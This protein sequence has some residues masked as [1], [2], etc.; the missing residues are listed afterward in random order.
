MSSSKANLIRKISYWAGA[1]FLIASLI[2]GITIGLAIF[3]NP[4]PFRLSP[5]DISWAWFYGLAILGIGATFRIWRGRLLLVVSLL[6]LMALIFV[7]ALK[8][9]LSTAMAVLAWWL[10]V[11]AGIGHWILIRF[12]LHSDLSFL[13]LICFGIGLGF[14]VFMLLGLIL[15]IAGLYYP[16]AAY[17]ILLALTVALVPYFRKNFLPAVQPGI[18]QVQVSWREGDLRL[19]A[20]GASLLLVLILG[21]Y[22]W[23]FAPPVRFDTLTYQ[24]AAPEIYIRHHSMVKI[25]E[26]MN[27]MLVHYA[28]MLYTYGML[29][30]GERLPGMVH[31]VFGLLATGLTYTLGK[32]LGNSY[33]GLIAALAFLSTPL[34]SVEIG[35]AYIDFITCFYAFAAIYS[36]FM[37]WE[38]LENR[39]LSFSGIFAGLT[40]GT[41]LTTA[42][43]LVT[44]IV[45][46]TILI[47]VR[48]PSWKRR[49]IRVC[50]VGFLVLLFASPWMIRDWLW[51]GTPLYPYKASWYQGS[52]Q[53]VA[54]IASNPNVVLSNNLRKLASYLWDIV[55]NSQKYYIES[56]GG[57][58]SA[59][60]FLALPW[61]YLTWI[62]YPISQRKRFFLL[63]IQIV[64]AT[65]LSVL[66]NFS[67]VRYISPVFPLMAIGAGLNFEALRQFLQGGKRYNGA[68]LSGFL[69]MLAYIFSTRL[70]VTV[71]RMIYPERYPLKYALGLQNKNE[72]LEQNLRIYST[73]EFLGRLEDSPQKILSLGNEFR[74]YTP[75]TISASEDESRIY[76]LVA[77]AASAA[78]LAQLLWEKGY[79]YILI[80]QPEV[81]ARPTLYTRAVPSQEFLRQFTKVA[82]TEQDISLYRLIPEGKVQSYSQNLLENNGF[83]QVDASGHP[84]A[85]QIYGLPFLENQTTLVHSGR[86]SLKLHGPE[87]PET[88][89]FVYQ[90]VLVEAGITYTVGY[91]TFSEE[92]VIIS[93]QIYWLDENHQQIGDQTEWK[94][95]QSGWNWYQMTTMAPVGTYYAQVFANVNGDRTAWFDDLCFV[96]GQICP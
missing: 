65:S 21:A 78:D 67:L 14:A 6:C 8:A 72:F 18:K 63:F 83:E 95:T 1:I 20:L 39:W 38:S 17:S 77:N 19:A 22:L 68:L 57:I 55:F 35:S 54:R 66:F 96:E 61:L 80:D 24:I 89:G 86:F 47:T 46:L 45:I 71:P 34:V 52:S 43:T 10:L 36:G 50:W 28:G 31:L 60:P 32:R 76:D 3:L 30:A 88:Y 23:S 62:K 87:P 81:L 26:S 56:P 40:L 53:F 4:A 75:A 42:P 33:V 16:P 44:Y 94:E 91:W 92:P 25:S 15:G 59:L 64:A 41:K 29:L 51:S 70:A 2:L 5:I 74:L 12:E 9:D 82:N 79:D 11:C 85:W 69:L 49:T 93:L 58:L 84:T 73:F 27:T 48:E 37:W 13:E 90:D 7:P